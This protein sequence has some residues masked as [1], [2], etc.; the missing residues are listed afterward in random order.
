MKEDMINPKTGKEYLFRSF[1][2]NVNPNCT[3]SKYRSK[4]FMIIIITYNVCNIYP[5]R[6]QVEQL[7]DENELLLSKIRLLEQQQLGGTNGELQSDVSSSDVVPQIVHDQVI[8]SSPPTPHCT[9][10]A[11]HHPLHHLSLHPPLH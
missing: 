9:H 8:G 11:L 10:P 3:F 5:P 6:I 4:A 2:V 1:S 7:Q